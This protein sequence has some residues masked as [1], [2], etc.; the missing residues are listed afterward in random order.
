M[1]YDN[2]DKVIRKHFKSLSNRYETGLETIYLIVSIYS[3]INVI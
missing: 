1:I 2:V 3:I